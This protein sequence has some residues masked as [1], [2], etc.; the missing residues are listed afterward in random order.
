[1]VLRQGASLANLE[2]SGTRLALVKFYLKRRKKSESI[3]I[4]KQK[5][6]KRKP[7]VIVRN[8]FFKLIQK[9]I[10]AMSFYV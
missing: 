7:L 3:Y 2:E 8:Y 1:M 5:R 9:L 6:Q 4:L 10:G